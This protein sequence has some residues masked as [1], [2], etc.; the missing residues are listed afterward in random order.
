IEFEISRIVSNLSHALLNN[1]DIFY[2]AHYNYEEGQVL[3]ESGKFKLIKSTNPINTHDYAISAY[4]AQ[5]LL[6]DLDINSPS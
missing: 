2:I 6:K 4:S 3:T 5:K 1:W